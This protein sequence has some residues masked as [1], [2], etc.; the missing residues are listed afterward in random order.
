MTI[1]AAHDLL[2]S[3]M[4]TIVVVAAPILAVVILVSLVV[5]VLQT[6]TQL[7]DHTLAFVPR[8]LVTAVL[9]LLLLPWMLGRV[10]EYAVDV[11]RAAGTGS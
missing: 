1:D 7:H 3:A 2:Q 6:M 8:L 9:L 10:S 11:Y 4:M 5:N